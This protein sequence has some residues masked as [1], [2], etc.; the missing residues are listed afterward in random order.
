MS[1]NTTL[2]GGDPQADDRHQHVAFTISDHLRVHLSTPFEQAKNGDFTCGPSA[3]FAFA[4]SAEVRLIDLDLAVERLTQFT[5]LVLGDEL[6]QFAKEQRRGV[7]VDADQ[8]GRG[9]RRRAGH[10]DF[11][12]FAVLAG[13]EFAVLQSHGRF[14]RSC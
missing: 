9:P 8:L 1:E 11:K 4:A 7:A 10:E 6:P 5:F 13:A 2:S 12:Q 3:T 14:R